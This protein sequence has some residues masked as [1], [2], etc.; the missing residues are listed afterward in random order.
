M[1]EPHAAQ[2]VRR[3]G[4]LDVVVA[5]DLYAVPP[6]VEEIEEL[7]GQRVHARL[8]QRLADG[9]LVIDHESKMAAGV[10]GLL[11]ALLQRQELVALLM[12]S[13][14]LSW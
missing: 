14:P 1:R 3:L 4:E 10:G 2:H 6:R 12:R 8:C 9:V 11:T 13:C 7:T 5:D